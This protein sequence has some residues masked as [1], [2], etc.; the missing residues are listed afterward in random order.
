MTRFAYAHASADAPSAFATVA[1]EL[2]T[3]RAAAS[4]GKTTLGWLYMTDRLGAHADALLAS[5]R[6]HW[7]GASWVGAVG[8]GICAGGTE[9][10]GEPALA[11]MLADLPRD[12]FRVFSGASPLPRKGFEAH[13]ALVHADPMTPDLADMVG[14]LSGR[15]ASGYLFGGLASAQPD[16]SAAPRMFTIAD[17]VFAGGLSGVAFTEA[18]PLVSRVSQGCLPIAARHSITAAEGQLVLE[19]DG[20]PALDVLLDELKL[21]DLQARDAI[22][23]LRQTLAGLSD[24]TSDERRRAG[25]F[26]PDVRVRH[27][28]GVDPGRRAV[29][30]ADLVP[31]HGELAFCMRNTEAA[32]RDLVRVCTEIREEFEPAAE[33]L[34]SGAEVGASDEPAAARIAGAVYV[35][36]AGRGGPHFGAPSAELA[37]VRRSLGDVPLVGFFAAGEIGR[38]HLYGYTGVLTAFGEG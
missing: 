19:L 34:A 27:L 15:M 29:A 32:R 5:A 2:D 12:R 25:A 11:I 26:G 37:I 16:G 21:P 30:L 1:R 6:A 9:Y 24:A 14:E 36:C 3:Q 28:I 20:R 7:P 13:A 33:L 35:S 38:R 4:A 22:P 18:V 8:V 10:F 17:G 31:E 23:R